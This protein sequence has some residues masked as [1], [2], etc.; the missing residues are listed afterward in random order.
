MANPGERFVYLQRWVR[1]ARRVLTSA[2]LAP[3]LST[4]LV[5][6][7]TIQ[8][9]RQDSTSRIIV[10]MSAAGGAKVVKGSKERRR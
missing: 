8:H 3:G 4:S 9:P 2:A 1:F 6:R 5:S 7:R 10:Y